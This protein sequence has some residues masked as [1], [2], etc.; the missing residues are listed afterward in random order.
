MLQ[1]EIDSV[2][3]PDLAADGLDVSIAEFSDT[4]MRAAQ[5]EL[6]QLE[7][8][9]IENVAELSFETTG[10][11][12]D[13]AQVIVSRNYRE[14]GA[15]VRLALRKAGALVAAGAKTEGCESNS[16]VVMIA[17]SAGPEPVLI[18]TRHFMDSGGL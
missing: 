1:L 7:Y 18:G 4:A 13:A 9:H 5:Q 6:I 12:G 15:A 8:G 3:V 2:I 16:T 10:V 14:P 17:F 11:G